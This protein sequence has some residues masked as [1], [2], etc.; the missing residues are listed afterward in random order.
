M[1]HGING[2]NRQKCTPCVWLVKKKNTHT[3]FTERIQ[4]FISDYTDRMRSTGTVSIEHP[5]K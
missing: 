1:H 2:F 3:Q 4:S 5:N